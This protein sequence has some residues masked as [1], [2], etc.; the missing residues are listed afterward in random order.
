MGEEST[1]GELASRLD[2]ES[3]TILDVRTQ[4]EYDGLIAA[5]CDPRAGHIPGARHVDVGELMMLEPEQ[6]RDRLGLPPGAE[7]VAY[8]HSGGRSAIACSLLRAGLRRAQLRRL[9]ARVV[10]RRRPAD[11]D[12]AR[13]GLT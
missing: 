13:A 6:I 2:D 7:V 12:D 9:V 1:T 11:R 3:L 4:E 10:A 5:P 8:C